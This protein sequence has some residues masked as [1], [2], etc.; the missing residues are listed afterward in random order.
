MEL[1]EFDRL[2]DRL[3]NDLS[4]LH[5]KLIPREQI[6]DALFLLY[7]DS[8]GLY[9]PAELWDIEISHDEALGSLSKFDFKLLLNPIETDLDLNRDVLFQTKVKV[10]AGGFKIVIHKYDKDPFPS[11]PHGHIIEQNLKIDLSNGKCYR[12]RKEVSS[13]GKKKLIEVRE[14]AQLRHKVALPPL[15]V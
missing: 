8:L 3:E 4:R 10:K 14:E 9:H 12:N 1:E 11:D 7:G 6:Y 2:L 15:T 5:Q 13:I